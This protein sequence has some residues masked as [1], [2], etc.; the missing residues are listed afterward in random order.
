M[1]T[2]AEN[3]WRRLIVWSKIPWIFRLIVIAMSLSLL[4][5]VGLVLYANRQTLL[6]FEWRVSWLPL[7][8]T[9]PIY[10]IALALVVLVWGWMLNRIG[11]RISWTHHARIYCITNLARRVPG[12]LWYIVGRMTTYEHLGISKSAITIS[13]GLEVA[14]LAMSGLIAGLMISPTLVISY[15]GNPL[16]LSIGL[17]TGLMAIHPAFIR[18][19]LRRLSGRNGLAE[20]LRYIDV[21]VWLAIYIGVWFLGGL[22]LCS[23]VA[24]IYP[25]TLSTVPAIIGAWAL[26][27][28]LSTLG[29]FLPANL[30]LHEV[31]LG[32]L[33]A[34]FLPIGVAITATVLIRVVL[35]LY[36]VMWALVTAR[37]LNSVSS[38]RE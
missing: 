2:Q 9:F 12:V 7:A 14:L 6:Q 26:S 36:E 34:L 15:L 4:I 1:L 18:Y 25:I 10:S 24:G 33:L 11:E 3:I 31:A 38:H 32:A 21:L 16:W 22:C 13:S 29:V 30:L 37:L 28:A 5:S 27:G 19:M 23:L 20:Q 8:A 35:T 17:L